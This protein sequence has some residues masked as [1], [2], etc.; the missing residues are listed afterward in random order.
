MIKK[1]TVLFMVLFLLLSVSGCGDYEGD[2][3]TEIVVFAASS[4]TE[5]LTEIAE[6]Y[7][8]E[9]PDVTI[10]FNFDSSGTLKT[11]IEEGALCDVFISASVTPM[12]NLDC[13]QNNTRVDLLENKV[14]LVV[15]DGNKKEITSFDDMSNKLK[16][17]EI[18][19]GIGNS[20]VPVGE[21]TLKIF[22][23]YDISIEELEDNGCI[24]Y[25]SNAKEV[26]T[27][28]SESLVDCGIIYQTDAY[29]AS[30]E[31]I[32]TATEEMCGKAIYPA[33]VLSTAQNSDEAVAFLDFLKNDASTQIFEKVGFTALC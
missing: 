30:L 21:Y 28:V 33:S 5:T 18:F 10:T 6:I 24:T 8:G 22:D 16:N 23:F 13:V 25:G 26:T 27:Q 3:N 2:K 14:A 7:V 1:F 12:D 17:N 31:V 29:S 4:L 9:N 11:Q 19:I 32:D 15:P 20:D